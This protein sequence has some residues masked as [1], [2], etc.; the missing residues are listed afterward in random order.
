MEVVLESVRGRNMRLDGIYEDAPDG[1]KMVCQHGIGDGI[2]E[3]QRT[4]KT[5]CHHQH[6]RYCISILRPP[7]SASFLFSLAVATMKVP[8]R[9]LVSLI[10][11]RFFSTAPRCLEIRSLEELPNRIQPS[12]QG[13]QPKHPLIKL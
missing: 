4:K 1:L 2:A 7:V 8:R 10:S 12:Y 5:E 3:L 11:H 9:R 13:W 6:H